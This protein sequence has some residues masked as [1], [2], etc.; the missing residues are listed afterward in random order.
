VVEWDFV[1]ATVKRGGSL[2]VRGA[3]GTEAQATLGELREHLRR[4]SLHAS[5]GTTE[6]AESSIR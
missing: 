5:A 2:S 1:V 4:Q 3:G 6:E